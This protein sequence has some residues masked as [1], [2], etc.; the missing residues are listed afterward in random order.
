[1]I[2]PIYIAPSILSADFSRLGECVAETE[3]AGAQ[4]VHID[5]MDGHFV[6]NLSMGPEVVRGLRPV[7]KLPLEIHLMV[8][9]PETFF[10]SFIEAGA[11]TLIFHHEVTA[12]PRPLFQQ[13]RDKGKKVGYAVNP[14][15][16]IEVFEPYLGEIDLALCM[17]V[18][19]GFAGQSYLKE[20]PP[21]IKRLREM[22]DRLNP[23]CE[24]EVDGGVKIDNAL[25]SVNA[26]A[27]VLVMASGL[28][29]HPEGASKAIE[30]TKAKVGG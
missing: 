22:I 19:P 4:R 30:L 25:D 23:E 2:R 29:K 20:S 15:T 10:E 21:R 26:G 5:V 14:E 6:P 3:K 18:H 9:N 27:N 7:T 11:D 13:L 16:N 12:D 24:L 17:T 8:E 28:F 1:M